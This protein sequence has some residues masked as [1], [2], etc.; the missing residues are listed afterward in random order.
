MTLQTASNAGES[1]T[2]TATE[3]GVRRVRHAMK[4]R[5]ITV[6]RITE[7]HPQTRC[8]TFGGGDLHAFVSASFN[9]HA[10]LF[11][12]LPGSL[13]PL[14]PPGP[15][16]MRGGPG[17]GADRGT[18]RGTDSGTDSGPR[19]VARDY[20]PRRHDAAAGELD[21]EF[22]LHGH[23]PAATWA[24]QAQPGQQLGLGGPRG[25][26]ILPDDLPWLCLLAAAA[27][28]WD[29][30]AGDGFVW[31]AAEASEVAALR[32]LLVSRWRLANHQIRAASYW[33]RGAVSHHEVIEG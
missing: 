28:S 5:R 26:F 13:E 16:G 2:A 24:A 7:T 33:K 8:I 21:I 11:F 17:S 12:P 9:D 4:L 20:T 23:G 3:S 10:K 25:S 19:P 29:R 22:L 6:L 14:V 27:A 30:P 32:Q 1:T 18:D 31:A 15:P